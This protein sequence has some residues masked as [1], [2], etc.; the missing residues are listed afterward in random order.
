[1]LYMSMVH[2]Y[3]D[4]HLGCLISLLLCFSRDKYGCVL[5]SVVGGGEVAMCLGVVYLGHMAVVF[6]SFEKPLA[7]F[8]NRVNVGSE[9]GDQER[10]KIGTEK[11]CG[12]GS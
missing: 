8:Y 7:G 5:I 3:A 4:R 11:G 9:K 12:D 1:M 6:L 10:I 2:S